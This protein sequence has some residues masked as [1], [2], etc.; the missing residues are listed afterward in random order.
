MHKRGRGSGR[1]REPSRM[2]AA[3]FELLKCRHELLSSPFRVTVHGGKGPVILLSLLRNELPS[4]SR[5]PPNRAMALCESSTNAVG[6]TSPQR[7]L[8]HHT[9]RGRLERGLFFFLL[10]QERE[11]IKKFTLGQSQN[12]KMRGAKIN[13]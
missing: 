4:S 13:D 5:F 6:A 11:A 1:V 8:R 7:E 2:I 12:V 3:Q 9:A 10:I